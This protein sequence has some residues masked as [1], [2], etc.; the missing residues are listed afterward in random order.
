MVIYMYPHK[1]GHCWMSLQAWVPLWWMMEAGV[2]ANT[3]VHHVVQHC[4]WT[5]DFRQQL[6][7]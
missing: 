7:V 4:F 5:L 3:N 1:Q 6:P 2:H